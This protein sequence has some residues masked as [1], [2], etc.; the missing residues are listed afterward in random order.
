MIAIKFCKTIKQNIKPTSF[1]NINGK[2]YFIRKW[3]VIRTKSQTQRGN[4]IEPQGLV[5]G[6]VTILFQRLIVLCSN[7]VKI[8]VKF[9]IYNNLFKFCLH[10]AYF[11][12]IYVKIVHFY[13]V[14]THERSLVKIVSI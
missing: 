8:G 10:S 12:K 4:Q 7:L 14:L 5:T 1:Y 11:L 13:G 9:V 6:L 3:A 2:L